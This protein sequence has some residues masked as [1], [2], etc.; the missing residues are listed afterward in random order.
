MIKYSNRLMKINKA[1]VQQVLIMMKMFGWK[2]FQLVNT[3]VLRY[4]N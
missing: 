4:R 2:L 3:G 1:I